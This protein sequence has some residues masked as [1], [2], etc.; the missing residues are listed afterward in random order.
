MRTSTPDKNDQSVCEKELGADRGN[1]EYYV[2]KR[3]SSR[4]RSVHLLRFILAQHF[5]RRELSWLPR[6]FRVTW[7]IVDAISEIKNEVFHCGTCVRKEG[8]R[9]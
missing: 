5:L 7:F 9:M 2:L 8:K 6:R 4:R 1:L 3:L